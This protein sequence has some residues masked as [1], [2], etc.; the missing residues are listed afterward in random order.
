MKLYNIGVSFML[1]GP[2]ARRVLVHHPM[3][4]CLFR[5]FIHLPDEVLGQV[6]F[7]ASEAAELCSISGY[8]YQARIVIMYMGVWG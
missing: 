4:C 7:R 1:S 2:G 6:I 3:R 8:R 5:T